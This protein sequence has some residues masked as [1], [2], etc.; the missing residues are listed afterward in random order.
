LI[1]RCRN[2][3]IWRRSN[4]S[5]W[6]LKFCF[7]SS[8]TFFFC[9]LIR[10]VRINRRVI[11]I[12]RWNF[13]LLIWIFLR[14]GFGLTRLFSFSN[15][16]FLCRCRLSLCIRIIWLCKLT[17]LVVSQSINIF[18]SKSSVFSAWRCSTNLWLYLIWRV[19]RL[20][21]TRIHNTLHFF[22]S[23]SCKFSFV[24][25]LRRVLKQFYELTRLVSNYKTR[26]KLKFVN[27][28]LLNHD[29]NHYHCMKRC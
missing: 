5:Y 19:W 21:T 18:T 16:S 14:N 29:L 7:F 9:F 2:S 27:Y 24:L 3:W 28:Y 17:F 1:L 25:K 6:S 23:L 15:V 8:S 11:R 12:I 22:S 26:E 4:L 20:I 10:I 13:F